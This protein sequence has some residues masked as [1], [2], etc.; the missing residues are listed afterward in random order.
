MIICMIL[1]GRRIIVLGRIKGSIRFLALS[2]RV[3][4]ATPL[5]GEWS[6]LAPQR[7]YP[8]PRFLVIVR[9]VWHSTEIGIPRS[10]VNPHC[11]ISRSSYIRAFHVGGVSSTSVVVFSANTQFIVLS[12]SLW[13]WTILKLQ[14]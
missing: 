1:V 10:V 13:R 12:S 8:S 3:V 14:K 11:F 4:L 2:V 6:G 7:V 5:N 9:L